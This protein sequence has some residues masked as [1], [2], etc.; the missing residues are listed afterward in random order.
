MHDLA[1][2]RACLPLPSP[3][4]APLVQCRSSARLD[5]E[6]GLLAGAV[7]RCPRTGGRSRSGGGTSTRWRP[8]RSRRSGTRCEPFLISLGGQAPR[9]RCTPMG[10]IKKNTHPKNVPALVR[11][12]AHV[13]AAAALQADARTRCKPF[14][15]IQWGSI[16]FRLAPRTYAPRGCIVRVASLTKSRQIPTRKMLPLFPAIRPRSSSL[17][18]GRWSSRAA[19]YAPRI[20][21]LNCTPMAVN[22]I[23]FGSPRVRP[24]GVHRTCGEPNESKKGWLPARVEGPHGGAS[25][26]W[27]LTA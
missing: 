14:N 17:R 7:H 12:Q 11:A 15:S 8:S 10:E 20:R 18:T 25:Y 16:R 3:A 6:R 1:A 26:V 4:L 5:G 27:C 13:R 9:V 24:T 2:N 21:V 22:P 19:R 23:P